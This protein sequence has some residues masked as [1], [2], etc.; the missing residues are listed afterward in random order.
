MA[1]IWLYGLSG[2]ASV[3]SVSVVFGSWFRE[4]SKRGLPDEGSG[5]STLSLF[6]GV[7]AGGERKR[8]DVLAF[9]GGAMV[10]VLGVVC[11]GVVRWGI[12][13]VVC[14]WVDVGVSGGIVSGNA[15]S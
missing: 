1:G 12:C 8:S 9:F 14:R 13:L 2:L 3:R 4:G 7:D 6:L 10:L 5:V 11:L 15:N